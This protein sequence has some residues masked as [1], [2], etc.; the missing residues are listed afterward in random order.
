MSNCELV[1]RKMNKRCDG[2]HEHQQLID[3]RAKAA[4]IYPEGLCRA[5]CK[6]LME[7]LR[8]DNAQVKS[9]LKVGMETKVGD[10]PEEET[11]DGEI[12]RAWDD[13][14][15]KELDPMG[16]RQA[17]AKEIEYINHK[18]VWQK[19]EKADAL[20]MGCKVVGGRWVD[21]D[22][23]DASRPDYRSRFVAKEINTG[24]EEG[25]YDSTPPLEALRWMLSETST[26]DEAWRQEEK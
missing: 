7:Q 11:Y 16:V 25:L 15:G 4:A 26:I 6:G 17:R 13:V 21:V 14:S 2:S 1:M 9:L 5:I 8:M 24:Y 12:A 10:S 20:K 23:G 19:A 3:G 22:K 18:N